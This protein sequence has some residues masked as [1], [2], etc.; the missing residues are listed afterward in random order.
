MGF[1]TVICEK[2]RYYKSYLSFFI[3]FIIQFVFE[4]P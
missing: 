1:V 4:A 2:D 3:D